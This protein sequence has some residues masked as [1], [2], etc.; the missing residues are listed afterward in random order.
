M[1]GIWYMNWVFDQVTTCLYCSWIICNEATTPTASTCP[2]TTV[3]Q[4]VTHQSTED[5]RNTWTCRLK[6][7]L[8]KR[9]THLHN[10][11]T[12]V[13]LNTGWGW[14]L[15]S[16]HFGW[17]SNMSHHIAP[18]SVPCCYL[19]TLFLFTLLSAPCSSVNIILWNDSVCSWLA[20]WLPYCLQ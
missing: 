19:Y 8:W 11:T 7:S 9:W 1:M 13:P 20:G 4:R 2:S 16:M 6:P 15:T 14:D 12:N 3:A 17:N 10:H 5:P 18:S